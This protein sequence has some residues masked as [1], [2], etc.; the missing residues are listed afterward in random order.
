MPAQAANIPIAYGQT[1]TATIASATASNTHPFTAAAGDSILVAVKSAVFEP[2]IT[3]KDSTGAELAATSGQVVDLLYKITTAGNYTLFID[4]VNQAA[5]GSYEITFNRLNN[6]VGAVTMAYHQTITGTS[7]NVTS[8]NFRKFTAQ[9]GDKI[10]VALKNTSPLPDFNVAVYDAAG[11]QIGPVASDVNGV[12]YEG[13]LPAA[14]VYAIRIFDGGYDMTGNFEMTLEKV[15]TPAAA[16]APLIAYHQTTNASLANITSQNLY[17]FNGQA[18]D[19][20]LVALKTPLTGFDLRIVLY[21]PAGNQVGLESGE[22]IPVESVTFIRSLPVAGTY[23]LRIFDGSYD[24]TGS[25][26]FVLERLN[27]PVAAPATAYHQTVTGALATAIS[28][29]FHT[30]NGQAGDKAMIAFKDVTGS[31]L[32]FFVALYDPAGNPVGQGMYVGTLAATMVQTLPATGTYSILVYDTLYDAAGSYQFTLDRLNAPITP[33][34]LIYGTLKTGSLTNITSH[35]S[36]G[37][38]AT[39][40]DLIT[41]DCAQATT[42]QEIFDPW[43]ELRDAAGNAIGTPIQSGALKFTAAATGTY[44]VWVRDSEYDGLGTFTMTLMLNLVKNVSISQVFITPS[45]GETTTITF[46]L[47]ANATVTMRLYP[48]S[49]DAFNQLQKGTPETIRVAPYTKGI[50]TFV[51]NGLNST[52]T[53]V[54]SGAHVLT[55]EAVPTAGVPFT[56]DPV[57]VPG[58]VTLTNSS[59][60][61]FFD[62]YK[63]ENAVIT[64]SVAAPAFV[65]LQ[66][67][68]MFAGEPARTIIASQPRFGDNNTEIWDGKTDA[69]EVAPAGSYVVYARMSILPEN[70]IAIRN[71]LNV[72]NVKVNPYVIYPIHGGVAKITYTVG[73]SANVT[74][75]VKDGAGTVVRTILN[76]APQ[77]PGDY[78]VTWDGMDDSG[79]VIGTAGNYRAVVIAADSAGNQKIIEGNVTVF[80]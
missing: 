70:A 45:Q 6:P 48:A 66:A 21:D 56:Y 16:A 59:L 72:S 31:P 50:R 49:L 61:S 5:G 52:G 37:F 75:A 24:T 4:D 3:L 18:G 73:V 23:V 77:T 17:R 53:P 47:M 10:V 40:G 34:T 60:G 62:P 68:I 30:F 35:L 38:T 36:Y 78:A 8:Q 57:Y 67:G 26:Q 65:T 64:Y 43:F 19:S 20:I 13:I 7:A 39:A 32:D 80:K 15:K 22:I 76:N 12:T 44:Y 33:D 42:T 74:V 9:A 55:I 1:R 46:E 11:N 54:K 28:Q 71:T 27:N 25:Y 41:I 58:V 14:G 63:S 51:W 69:G 2:R 29:N 79:K